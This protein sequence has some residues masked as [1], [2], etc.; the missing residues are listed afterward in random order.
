MSELFLRNPR[1]VL[2]KN[3]QT[4]ISTFDNLPSEQRYIFN[5]TP[6]NQ[7][8][9]DARAAVNG[10]AGFVPRDQY[11]SYHLSQQAPLEIPGGGT[12][13]IA[14]P[15]VFPIASN[16]SMAIFS[17]EPGAMREIHWHLTSDEWSFF[18]AG[19]AR[20]TSFAGPQNSRTFNFQAG[21]VGYVPVANSHYIENIGNETV[22]YMEVLQAPK[23]QDV[24][25][26]QWLGLTPKQV[27]K[28]TLN[29]P[30][31]FLE[32]LPSTKQYIVPGNPD[33]TTT[34][35]TV[36]S[37]PNANVTGSGSSRKTMRRSARMEEEAAAMAWTRNRAV[38]E[39]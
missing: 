8:L 20:L 2:A 4:D 29:L 34:N 21:D 5:G 26:S 22:V 32:T 12:V 35:F 28:D 23:Y 31:G 33:Y 6:L 14:D 38:V 18:I 9:D 7:S 27:V 15:T 17:I 10:P 13:K 1:E 24:S 36:A 37:Y 16:F 39:G 30:D 19:Q 25:A 3:F 11:Y